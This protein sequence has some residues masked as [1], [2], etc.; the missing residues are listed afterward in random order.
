MFQSASQHPSQ[1][2]GLSQEKG[3][4]QLKPKAPLFKSSQGTVMCESYPCDGCGCNRIP[5]CAKGCCAPHRKKQKGYNNELKG[6]CKLC[7]KPLSDLGMLARYSHEGEEGKPD[8]LCK[9]IVCFACM[10]SDRL[11]QYS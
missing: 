11:M 7:H 10:Q 3:M 4:M 2:K 5:I 6:L 8:A 1:Q 9:S